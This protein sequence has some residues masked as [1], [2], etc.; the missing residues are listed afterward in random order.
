MQYQYNDTLSK[1]HARILRI[2]EI[3]SS[4]IVLAI[5]LNSLTIMVMEKKMYSIM[6]SMFLLM[7][8][9]ILV[10]FRLTHKKE[11]AKRIISLIQGLLYLSI[12]LIAMVFSG[13]P[14][15][16]QI[17]LMIYLISLI[18]VRGFAVFR[19]SRV[20]TKLLNI[21]LIL[22][23]FSFTFFSALSIDY[24]PQ[25]KTEIPVDVSC[26]L[27]TSVIVVLHYSIKVIGLAFRNIR[28]DI[29]LKVARRSMAVEILSGLIILVFAFSLLFTSIEPGM[30]NFLDALWYCFALVTTIGFG[31]V[32]ALT[33]TGRVLS[34][35]LGAYGIIVVALI[36]SII[37]NFYTELKSE[38]A[39]KEQQSSA[40]AK[41]SQ[42]EA[43]VTEEK[44]DNDEQ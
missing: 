34:F 1:N 23:L 24:D 3:I 17:T 43:P 39:E 10:K 8:L 2:S 36:T 12:A 42:D 27:L 18:I 35:I 30:T 22:V 31:D 11:K 19:K 28:F 9:S 6:S 44:P 40:Q 29:L 20:I 33:I 32:T 5:A 41:K 37:V 26:F 16:F 21:L 4:M 38:D 25:V 14:N 7:L 13:Y 15:V